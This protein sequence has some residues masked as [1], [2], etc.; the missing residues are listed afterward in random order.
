MATVRN[1][2]ANLLLAEIA[3]VEDLIDLEGTAEE[4]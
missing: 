3:E 2:F 4:Q 1:T